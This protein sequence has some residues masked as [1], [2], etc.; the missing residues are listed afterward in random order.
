MTQLVSPLLLLQFL[1][2]TLSLPRCPSQVER[3][4]FFEEKRAHQLDMMLNDLPP[5]PQQPQPSTSTSHSHTHSSHTPQRHKPQHHLH[6]ASSNLLRSAL[7]PPRSANGKGKAREVLSEHNGRGRRVDEENEEDEEEDGDETAMMDPT[8]INKVASS[9]RRVSSPA[10][11]GRKVR[12]PL[13]SP[14]RRL[15]GGEMRR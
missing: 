7:K 5:T 2:L 1:P 12:F 6:H 11:G 3:I 4:A 10:A 15:G 8:I 9:P 14:R 13:G